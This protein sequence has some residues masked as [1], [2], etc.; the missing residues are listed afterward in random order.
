MFVKYSDNPDGNER[1]GNEGADGSESE[2]ADGSEREGESE[3]DGA[4]DLSLLQ[5]RQ[6]PSSA[7]YQM[8][9]S[10]I[11][12]ITPNIYILINIM[13]FE[14][15]LLMY[16]LI[17]WYVYNNFPEVVSEYSNLLPVI[18]LL[19]YYLISTLRIN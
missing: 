5:D 14:L 12:T 4:T 16:L 7:M 17:T 15:A 2:G 11:M 18:A 6:N 1:A 19:S 10:I 9:I 8:I 3:R 13:I